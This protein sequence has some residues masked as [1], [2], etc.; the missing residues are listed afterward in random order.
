MVAMALEK[1]LI[2]LPREP[3][4]PMSRPVSMYHHVADRG[5]TRTQT[6]IEG[7]GRSCA[8]PMLYRGEPDYPRGRH[9]TCFM[10][11]ASRLRHAHQRT[12]ERVPLQA[13]VQDVDIS[14]PA[15]H[16]AKKERLISYSS[17]AS[18]TRLSRCCKP[19]A[20]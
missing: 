20:D 6:H 9:Q 3:P 1:H 16:F 19:K 13:R 8:P 14:S 10:S 5:E 2:S 7:R 12:V 17:S 15:V 11:L 4:C 18:R